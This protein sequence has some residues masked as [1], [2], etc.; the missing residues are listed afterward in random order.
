[1]GYDSLVPDTEALTKVKLGQVD[2]T[3]KQLQATMRTIGNLD[4]RLTTLESMVQAALFKQ[5]DDIK[6]LVV[7]VNKL[8]GE[9]EAKE[10]AKKFDMDAMPAE[11]GG[12]PPV[13]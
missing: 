11:Y 8:K 6:A 1:M 13:G 4:E 10:A 12:A 2:R 7:E 9:L 5:Q 3:K